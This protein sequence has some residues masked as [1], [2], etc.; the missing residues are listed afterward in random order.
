M[1]DLDPHSQLRSVDMY[2]AARVRGRRTLL[3][4]S[5][6]NVAYRAGVGLQDYRDM[7]A[8]RRRIGAAMIFELSVILDV[9][10]RFFFEGY[11]P[12]KGLDDWAAL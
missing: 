4:L 8:G 9:P 12:G 2:V 6:D 3:R 5:E 7:E 10:V 1:P 11:A